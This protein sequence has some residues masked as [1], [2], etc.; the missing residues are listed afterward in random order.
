MT[1]P[2]Q[3]EE[4]HHAKTGVKSGDTRTTDATRKPV[5]PV[6]EEDVFGGA[7]RTKKNEEVESGGTKP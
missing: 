3:P 2:R 5:R 7:E 1:A 4:P 6:E